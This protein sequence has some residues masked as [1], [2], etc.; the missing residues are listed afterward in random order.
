MVLIKRVSPRPRRPRR[1]LPRDNPLAWSCVFFKIKITHGSPRREKKRE[2]ERDEQ[3]EKQRWKS[4]WGMHGRDRGCIRIRTGLICGDFATEPRDRSRT[5]TGSCR[6]R[7]MRFADRRANFVSFQSTN[8][9]AISPLEEG[10]RGTRQ[11]R[12]IYFEAETQPVS[13]YSL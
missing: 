10:R 3:G 9:A 7:P 12:D 1:L 6:I 13:F 4:G 2:R 8:E 5:I 11:L